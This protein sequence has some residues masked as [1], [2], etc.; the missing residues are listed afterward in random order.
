MSSQSE[1][2]IDN[3]SDVKTGNVVLITV[4][5]WGYRDMIMSWWLNIQHYTP[6]LLDK[7][8]VVVWEEQLKNYLTQHI[9]KIKIHFVKY[10][11]GTPFKESIAYKNKG[12]DT[13][14]RFKLLAI[15]DFILQNKA[16]LYIDPD[17]VLFK[18]IVVY[19]ASRSAHPPRGDSTADDVMFI[20]QGKPYC[21]GVLFVPVCAVSKTLF[22]P[23]TWKS[24]Q[25]DDERYIIDFFSKKKDWS[26]NISVLPQEEF[27]NGLFEERMW[28][29]DANDL[30]K[31]IHKKAYL[32]HFNYISGFDKKCRKMKELGYW[33]SP[34][35]IVNV[36]TL[37]QPILEDV[38][39][40]QK[41]SKYPSHQTGPQIETYF[42]NFILK[43]MENNVGSIVCSD[44][45]YIPIYWTAIA[46]QIS[47][48][49][50][51]LKTQCKKWITDFINNNPDR[52]CFTVVQHCKG[53]EGTLGVIFPK[54]WL[55][56]STSD[57]NAANNINEDKLVNGTLI[58]EDK[59][60]N[61]PHNNTNY[62]SVGKIRMLRNPPPLIGTGR[63]NV[64]PITLPNKNPL[65]NSIKTKNLPQR[66]VMYRTIQTKFNTSRHINI[67][68]LCSP[69]L[70]E[71]VKETSNRT[72]LASFI[73]NLHIHPIRNAMDKT[74]SKH[75]NIVISDGK[76]L[77]P[78]DVKTFENL[79]KQSTFALCPR[80]YGNTSFRLVE[81]MEFG[82][83]PVYISDVHTLPFK[84]DID[85]NKCCVVV[86]EADLP[87]LYDLLV[88]INDD[89]E[90]L[91][92]MR[93]YVYYVYT[94][95][96][97]YEKCSNYILFNPALSV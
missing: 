54:E 85:W 49:G 5:N 63:K 73:G 11:P 14:S 30:N 58:H 39:M 75:K 10:E 7:V 32:L 89:I 41:R 55:I 52:K 77:N 94:T 91:S 70:K 81:A 12:W 15:W 40:A 23:E 79:M 80:G 86:A 34:L 95:Y 92:E 74:L 33:K 90:K 26:S 76:Y 62:L 6:H 29:Q 78:S 83:I 59:L 51:K 2:D 48:E 1:D 31:K 71:P 72:Y 25:S 87:K 19:F 17:V 65:T 38:C 37:F 66:R 64:Y 56:F 20:Q 47:P 36:P 27:P 9:P 57:P 50:I 84:D 43:T 18:D 42:H 67:P 88:K 46:I 68:L 45:E 44:Y 96:F 24:W 53:I 13:V 4:G 35:K 60:I 21:S 3:S 61:I 28:I 8:Y 93:E 97:T 82:A 22:N 69:H 16:V